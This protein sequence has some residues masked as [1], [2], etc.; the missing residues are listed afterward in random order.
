MT[1]SYWTVKAS[2]PGPGSRMCHL[3][4]QLGCLSLFLGHL[5]GKYP[6]PFPWSRTEEMRRAGALLSA[7][8]FKPSASHM[9]F[10]RGI[11]LE[12]EQWQVLDHQLGFPWQ[13]ISLNQQAASQWIWFPGIPLVCSQCQKSC[14]VYDLW[15]WTF[16]LWFVSPSNSLRNSAL[17]PQYQFNPLHPVAYSGAA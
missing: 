14:Q 4:R 8:Q 10:S 16:S 6:C 9:Q 12:I 1:T 3:I 2:I 17:S 11:A 5:T 13:Y 7:V 15:I